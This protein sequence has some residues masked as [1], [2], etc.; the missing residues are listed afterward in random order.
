M[1]HALIF[2][3]IVLLSRVFVLPLIDPGTGKHSGIVNGLLLSSSM[4]GAAADA[5][6]F[7]AGGIV[8]LGVAPP[9]TAIGVVYG[10]QGHGF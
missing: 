6:A 4:V 2:L 8:A 10:D 9:D 1:V 7:V 5:G 3:K